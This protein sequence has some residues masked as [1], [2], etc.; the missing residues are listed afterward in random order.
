MVKTEISESKW[1]VAGE[2]AD[3]LHVT[4]GTVKKYCRGKELAGRQIGPKKRWFVSGADIVRKREEWGLADASL[5][6]TT[7]ADP[8]GLARARLGTVAD[9]KIAE[10]AT[11]V[12][13]LLEAELE[14]VDTSDLPPLWL[15][16]GEYGSVSI[17]WMFPHFRLGFSI[18]PDEKDSGWFFVSDESAGSL[19]ACGLLSD[20]SIRPAVSLILA[21]LTE[22][23]A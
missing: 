20:A 23:K 1:Y 10:A 7:E 22:E 11:R 14:S 15:V 9:K 13:D 21:H 12:L 17:E 5:A 4:E 8:T 16:E 3:L 19:N 2:A 18:E 6:T